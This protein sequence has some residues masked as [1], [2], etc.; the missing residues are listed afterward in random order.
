MIRWPRDVRFG[1]EPGRP[2]YYE[3]W[4]GPSDDPH[5]EA[6]EVRFETNRP[7]NR[8]AWLEWLR[9]H[10]VDPNDVLVPGGWIRRDRDRYR[11]VY[12]APTRTPD[13][14]IPAPL[15]T[16][17]RY[18]QLEGPPMLFPTLDRDP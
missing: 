13:G 18:V 6:I 16:V 7:P 2:I 12:L 5:A 4:D 15:T 11:V 14:R 9:R 17:E 1:I 8:D 3:L 10:S